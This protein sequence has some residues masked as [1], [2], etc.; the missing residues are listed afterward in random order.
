MRHELLPM[1]ERHANVFN[2]GVFVRLSLV[3][4]LPRLLDFVASPTVSLP[5][6]LQQGIAYLWFAVSTFAIFPLVARLGMRVTLALSALLRRLLGARSGERFGE[7][8]R[9]F[10]L[11]PIGVLIATSCAGAVW[12]LLYLLVFPN[13]LDKS[14]LGLDRFQPLRALQAQYYYGKGKQRAGYVAP[15][16]DLDAAHRALY[17]QQ[18]AALLLLILAALALAMPKRDNSRG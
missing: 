9:Y 15:A 8:L 13:R 18:A 12:E 7:S 5:H 4:W 3:T 1:L 17:K 2:A 16:D 14:R 11:A 10:C 6:A